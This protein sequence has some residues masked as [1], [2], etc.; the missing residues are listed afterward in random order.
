MIDALFRL[1]RGQRVLVL[2]S[3]PLTV[4]LAIEPGTVVVACNGG[5][6]HLSP[7]QAVDVWSVNARESIIESRVE[8]NRVMMRQG[9]DRSIPLAI[10]H[11]RGGDA[12]VAAFLRHMKAQR[13]IIAEYVGLESQAR[14]ELGAVA[15]EG[16]LMRNQVISNGILTVAL[17]C[18]HGASRVV[19]KGF[20]WKAGYHYVTKTEIKARGH[21]SADKGGLSNLMRHYPG[22]IETELIV[23]RI[24]TGAHMVKEVGQVDRIV[25]RATRPGF[26]GGHRRRLGDEFE[27]SGRSQVRPS[28]ME[29]VQVIAAPMRDPEADYIKEA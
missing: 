7:E 5:I 4:P 23:P 6:G 15:Y 3:A 24:L 21:V 28:W 16:A 26:Y 13:T 29:V 9:A 14:H 2:G 10:L 8:T 27:V 20:S 17:C 11:S 22:V 25:V 1:V 18:S 19:M 12:G